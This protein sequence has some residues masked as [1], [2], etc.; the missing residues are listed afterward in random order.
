MTNAVNADYR[1][2]ATERRWLLR[3][4]WW[5]CLI[6]LCGAT[7]A[8]PDLWGH[9]LYGMRAVEAGVLT[10]RTDPFSYTAAGATWI[11]HEWLTEYQLGWLWLKFGNIGLIAWRNAWVI[12]L[13]SLVAAALRRASVSAS[14]GLFLMVFNAEVLS[15]F[16]IFVRPQL[17]TFA[18]FAVFLFV[19]RTWWDETSNEAHQAIESNGL[20]RLSFKLYLLPLIMVLWTNMHGGFLAGIGVLGVFTF[21]AVW[22]GV[23]DPTRRR[24]A[25]ELTLVAIACGLATLLNPYGYRMHEM[26]WQHLITEQFVREWQP[27]WATG[28]APVLCVPFLIVLLGFSKS[29]RWQWIDAAVFAVV[30]WQAVFH[31]RHVALLSIAVF[32]VLPVPASEALQRLFPQ[33][34]ERW[35]QPA[36]KLRRVLAVGLIS[37]FLLGIQARATGEL[38]RSRV[39]PWQVAVEC[40]GQV[41][42]MPVDALRFLQEHDLHGNLITD[43][44]WGQ[45]VIWHRFPQ[46]KVAFDG[47]Y[48]TVYSHEIEQQFLDWQKADEEQT[49]VAMIDDHPTEIALLPAGRATDRWLARRADWACV[50]RDSQ[51]AVFVKRIPKFAAIYE[52]PLDSNSQPTARD[53]EPFP[54]LVRK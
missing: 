33:L 14:A 16:V 48:R 20:I 4:V 42:G 51:A 18:C 46:T 9:T 50:F 53:W 27:V 30:G 34:V 19:L 2:E 43:Y 11:N 21:A 31:L 39:A 41:P 12:V 35:S 32:I 36:Y 24:A 8:D 38:W 7:L 10:E 40:R 44:G 29:R 49:R 13:W 3:G 28:L 23:H 22:R 1:S 6:Y 26:L 15:D 52:R 5:V 54:G 45:F 47:R 37:V 25:I 17:A